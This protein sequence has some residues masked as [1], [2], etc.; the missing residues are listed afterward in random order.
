[1]D[2]ATSTRSRDRSDGEGRGRKETFKN[3]LA[4]ITLLGIFFSA[5]IIS[6]I[7]VNQQAIHTNEKTTEANA[8]LTRHIQTCTARRRT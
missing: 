2:T 3:G 6:S 1:M 8:H 5:P 7:F 4:R